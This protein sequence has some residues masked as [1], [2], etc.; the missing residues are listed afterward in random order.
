MR[1]G[2]MGKQICVREQCYRGVLRQGACVVYMHGQ[3]GQRYH[4]TSNKQSRLSHHIW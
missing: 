3:K 4:L 2:I 1:L